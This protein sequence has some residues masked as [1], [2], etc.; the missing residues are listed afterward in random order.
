MQL[1]QP[2]SRSSGNSGDCRNLEEEVALHGFSL[3]DLTR[4]FTSSFVMS[5]A[6]DLSSVAHTRV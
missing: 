1:Q 6:C 2:D 4:S 5:G 3:A